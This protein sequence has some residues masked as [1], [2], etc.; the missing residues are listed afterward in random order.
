[1]VE[2]KDT[3]LSVVTKGKI[4]GKDL[5]TKVTPFVLQVVGVDN[6]E[7]KELFLQ[8]VRSL[9]GDK[10][11]PAEQGEHEQEEEAEED[12]EEE[13]EDEEEEEEEE[14]E[15]DNPDDVG[16]ET[17][18]QMET[19]GGEANSQLK[20]CEH[21]GDCRAESGSE[22]EFSLEGEASHRLESNVSKE[23]AKSKS[24]EG[25]HNDSAD[26]DTL[27]AL[28]GVNKK[29]LVALPCGHLCVCTAKKCRNQVERKLK[30]C[31]LCH[32][33]LRGEKLVEVQF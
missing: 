20:E 10:P 4:A 18:G 5:H 3:L 11:T 24:R 8:Q 27:C 2:Y 21:E 15:E 30:K 31:P 7:V 32:A 22:M 17:N 16:P 29:K 14:E 6:D 13:E 26:K 28:C 1:V 12:E 33:K 9:F 23:S 19:D 25:K